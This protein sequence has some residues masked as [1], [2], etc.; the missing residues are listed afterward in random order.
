MKVRTHL[1]LGKKLKERA[2]DYA[3]GLE[4]DLSELVAHL[5]RQELANPTIG[6]KKTDP[7]ESALIV[8][9]S[10]SST[11]RPGIVMLE[12]LADVSSHFSEEHGEE[13]LRAAEDPP[14][15]HKPLTRKGV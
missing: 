3:E 5:L 6:Q 4:M 9:P 2:A 11:P 14:K 10:S 1:S 8:E 15:S 7:V 12:S 13:S